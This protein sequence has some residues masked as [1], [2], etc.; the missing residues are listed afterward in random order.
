MR[1]LATITLGTTLLLVCNSAALFAD[2]FGASCSGANAGV[3]VTSQDSTGLFIDSVANDS[4]PC[5]AST[6]NQ[7]TV[8]VIAGDQAFSFTQN[9]S[10]SASAR[11]S[12]GS[13]GA[14]AS[15]DA[16]STPESYIF[17]VNGEAQIVDDGAHAV[18]GAG[19]SAMWF[20]TFTNRTPDT[21]ELELFSV[22]HSSSSGTGGGGASGETTAIFQV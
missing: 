8:T 19:A 7:S 14:R 20:D 5:G 12:L 15:A 22:F 6:Q 16:S 4:G 17:D 11:A 21:I 1:R 18:S 9:G 2:N 10:A 13:L 3:N